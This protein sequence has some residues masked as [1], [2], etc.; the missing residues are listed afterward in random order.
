MKRSLLF[1]WHTSEEGG[2]SG[3]RYMADHA[4]VPLDKVSAQLNIDMVGR[5]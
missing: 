4:V 2:L 3:S 1:V 5:E